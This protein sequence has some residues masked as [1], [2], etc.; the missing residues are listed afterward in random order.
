LRKIK[1]PLSL[2]K[3]EGFFGRKI[4]KQISLYPSLRKRDF[5]LRKCLIYGFSTALLLYC[6]TAPFTLH[7][8]TL[9]AS[10]KKNLPYPSL[11]KRDFLEE[12]LINKSPFIP[13]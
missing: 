12:K 5:K 1:S 7:G 4:N 2:F 9:H 10:R 3:K 8:F 13:L 6:S 11:R